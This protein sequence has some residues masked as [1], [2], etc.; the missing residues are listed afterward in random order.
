MKTG[1]PVI[2]DVC[3]DVGY[4]SAEEEEILKSMRRLRRQAEGVRSR[5]RRGGGDSEEV[6]ELE[7]HLQALRGQWQALDRKREAANRRKLVRLG[8][9]EP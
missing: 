6:A 9:L 4:V 7:A 1:L 3:S 5:L 2:Q 8:H